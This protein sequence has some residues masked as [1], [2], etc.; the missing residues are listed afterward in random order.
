M[1]AAKPVRKDDE[2]E[3]AVGGLGVKPGALRRLQDAPRVGHVNLDVSGIGLL[4]V[5]DYLRGDV[6]VLE[7]GVH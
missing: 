2:G 6:G 7:V 4:R 1:A 5:G 3:V